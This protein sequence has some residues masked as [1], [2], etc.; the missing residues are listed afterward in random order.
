[1]TTEG[2]IAFVRE[3]KSEKD[4]V[5]MLCDELP[6][7]EEAVRQLYIKNLIDNYGYTVENMEL[8]R[9]IDLES[10]CK[11][12]IEVAQSI[13]AKQVNKSEEPNYDLENEHIDRTQK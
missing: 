8:E 1:M 12:I 7:L 4:V 13:V 5:K 6:K 3:H 10:K 2:K 9:Q 11:D